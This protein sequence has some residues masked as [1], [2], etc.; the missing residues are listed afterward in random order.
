MWGW[1]RHL[2]DPSPEHDLSVGSGSM[3]RFLGRAGKVK[4]RV[5]VSGGWLML[6][7]VWR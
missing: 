6:E 1:T 4:G 3:M 2:S 5:V 7:E